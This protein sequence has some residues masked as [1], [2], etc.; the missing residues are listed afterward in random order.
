M[1]DNPARSVNIP[2]ITVSQSDL[3]GSPILKVYDE[4][5][6]EIKLLNDDRISLLVT[7]FNHIFNTSEFHSHW[8]QSTFATFPKVQ[9]K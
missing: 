1:F 4:L 6:L 5:S 2:N 7:L 8:L 3:S 9:Q